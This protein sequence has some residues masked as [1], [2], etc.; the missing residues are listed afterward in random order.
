M[1]RRCRCRCLC[2][3]RSTC[4]VTFSWALT[5]QSSWHR[6]HQWKIH[7][8]ASS[9]LVGDFSGLVQK[10]Y[11]PV[12]GAIQRHYT[13]RAIAPS[14]DEIELYSSLAFAGT[15]STILAVRP[16]FVAFEMAFTAGETPCPHT[17]W[18]T[19]LTGIV[20][21]AG[22]HQVSLSIRFWSNSFDFLVR[23]S[24]CLMWWGLALLGYWSVWCQIGLVYC[25]CSRGAGCQWV[26]ISRSQVRLRIRRLVFVG[27]H[28][29]HARLCA[30]AL[31]TVV[32][33]V[34]IV[35]HGCR[36]RIRVHTEIYWSS[37][38]SVGRLAEG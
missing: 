30:A 17:F 5:G 15:L 9:V 26:G 23:F 19:A 3:W 35:K 16:C 18:L 21:I 34:K 4:G 10:F 22:M 38:Q 11:S 20:A 25:R 31:I 7:M 6:L 36:Y 33:F 28:G 37:I 2:G 24:S 12:L 1:R 13:R 14:I 8:G 29:A 32:L 27:S